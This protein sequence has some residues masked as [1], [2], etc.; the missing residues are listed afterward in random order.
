MRTRA[1]SSCGSQGHS[2]G[3]GSSHAAI[4][5]ASGVVVLCDLIVPSLLRGMR[6]CPQTALTSLPHGILSPM[7]LSTH[8]KHHSL[9]LCLFSCA[10]CLLRPTDPLPS[11]TPAR[12]NEKKQSWIPTLP[13]RSW[14]L[15]LSCTHLLCVPED[16]AIG[17][18][19]SQSFL[20]LSSVS[21]TPLDSA[22][23]SQCHGA[24]RLAQPDEP[25]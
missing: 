2:R 5:E 15:A 25:W 4:P 18:G 19:H 3:R 13:R 10:L 8:G 11:A 23:L 1:P 14:T 21:A 17:Q 16:A 6:D 9:P 20:T 7:V 12:C 24:G 22:L